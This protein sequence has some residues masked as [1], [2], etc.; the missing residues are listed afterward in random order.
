ML[1]TADILVDGQPVGA[2]RRVRNAG[3]TGIIPAG[4]HERIQRIGLALRWR[5][6]LRAGCVF[7]AWVMHQRIARPV[8]ADIIGQAHRQVG[9]WYRH[10]TAITTMDHR[11]RTAPIALSAHTPITQ[12]IGRLRFAEL[13]GFQ[14]ADGRLDRFF[15]RQAVEEVRIIDRARPGIGLLVNLVRFRRCAGRQHNRLDWQLI[16]PGEI[17]VTLIAGGR[18]E[19]RA[20]AVRRQNEVR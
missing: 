4:I 1:D 16:F 14:L 13:Q 8:E 11:D 7:P 12:A 3:K 19:N 17:E 15:G 18:A 20:G 10:D 6:A 5:T 9:H 2:L